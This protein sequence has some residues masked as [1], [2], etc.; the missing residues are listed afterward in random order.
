LGPVSF[1]SSRF[2]DQ[3]ALIPS[4][5]LDFRE[6]LGGEKRINEYCRSLAIKGGDILAQILGTKIMAGTSEIVLN[7]V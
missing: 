2:R 3:I 6:S 5:A 1:S 4:I 7:M